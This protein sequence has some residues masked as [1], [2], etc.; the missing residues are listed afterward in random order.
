MLLPPLL[1]GRAGVE[2]HTGGKV[3]CRAAS[4]FAHVV[5]PFAPPLQKHLRDDP[6]GY[7]RKVRELVAR[8]LEV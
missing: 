5:V 7:R 6:K 2:R 8:S 4:V 3:G 1:L